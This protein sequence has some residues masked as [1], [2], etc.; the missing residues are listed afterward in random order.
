[1]LET[2]CF[3]YDIVI[4]GVRVVSYKRHDSLAMMPGETLPH[5]AVDLVS[6]RYERARA[7]GGALNMFE[8]GT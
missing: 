7:E 2:A 3:N 8:T 4:E 5:I 6:K 1:M